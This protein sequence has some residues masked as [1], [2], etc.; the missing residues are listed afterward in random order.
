MRRCRSNAM[1]NTSAAMKALK[2]EERGFPKI[3]TNNTTG[4]AYN[5]RFINRYR[6]KAQG[7]CLG[8]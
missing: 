2:C 6:L 8:R 5:D 7:F 1:V 3:Q 4:S